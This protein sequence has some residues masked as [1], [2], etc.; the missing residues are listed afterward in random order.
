[1][2]ERATQAKP[3]QIRARCSSCRPTAA[4][5]AISRARSRRAEKALEVAPERRNARLRKAE[6]LLDIGFRDRQAGAHRGGPRARRRGAR[7]AA[8]QPGRAVRAGQARHRREQARRR[9]RGAAPRDRLQPDWAQAHFLL[10]S[11]LRLTGR[12]P[13]AR[14]ELA[15]ALELDARCSRRAAA[16]RGARGSRRARP[17]GRGGAPLSAAAAATSTRCACASRR[18]WCSWAAS[19]RRSGARH[20]S[21]RPA[22]AESGL[23]DRAAS[24]RQGRER[25][26]ARDA[27]EGARV[28]PQPPGD[29]ARSARDRG[30][31]GKRRG[32]ARAHRE[33]AGGEAR[34]RQAA[35]ARRR[36]GAR[37]GRAPT[38]PEG[39]RARD[40][41][42][43]RTTW[44]ATS[45][46][47][48]LY[49]SN[50]PHHETIETYEKA[51]ERKPDQPR[52]HHFL[53]VLYECGGEPERR[54]RTTRRRSSS[55]PTSR[56]ARTTSRT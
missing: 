18:A 16:R 1:M 40:R 36:R 33:G 2:I 55:R 31:E 26:G 23:R 15:R 50:R 11:A 27:A 34:R 24:T 56:I 10:G 22:R 51:L 35:A 41:A 9:D 6:L 46:S 48:D 49:V 53:G 45:S 32:V 29:P 3:D 47:R 20:R 12:P 21:R 38:T 13:A 28:A 43:S 19:T 25:E 14:T 4:A 39:A 7:G 17:R 37:A 52:I 42:R 54:S 5:T 8:V 44:R 30:D